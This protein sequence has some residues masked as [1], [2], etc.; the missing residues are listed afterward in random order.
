MVA[1]YRRAIARAA[2]S[3]PP[4]TSLPSHLRPDPLAHAREL[5]EPFGLDPDALLR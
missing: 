2:A 1:G 4:A 5:L 3:T